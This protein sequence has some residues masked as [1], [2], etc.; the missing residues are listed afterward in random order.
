MQQGMVQ[1]Q[2]GYVKSQQD[3]ARVIAGIG[4]G[5]KNSFF[6]KNNISNDK[7]KA[8]R[9]ITEPYLY[10]NLSFN[11]R[12]QRNKSLRSRNTFNSLNLCIQQLHQMLIIPTDNFY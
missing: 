1:S 2:Q 9:S 5:Q 8:V 10:L 6:N 4:R 3:S 12:I 11:L 7:N